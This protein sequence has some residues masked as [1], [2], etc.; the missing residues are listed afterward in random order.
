MEVSR[1][2]L[3]RFHSPFTA[4]A[5]SQAGYE[6]VLSLSLKVQLD[7]HFF[8][9]S[10]SLHMHYD[11]THDS[12]HQNVHNCL[13]KEVSLLPSNQVISP[14]PQSTLIGN[15]IFFRLDFLDQEFCKSSYFLCKTKSGTMQHALKKSKSNTL[16]SDL[17]N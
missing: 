6:P 5:I 3:E 11:M 12:S 16:L 2:L 14:P 9:D 4:P 7:Y 1:K 10:L 13:K 8:L 17:Q 15:F